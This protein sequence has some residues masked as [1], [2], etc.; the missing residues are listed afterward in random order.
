MRP[1]VLVRAGWTPKRF[2]DAAAT[3]A[4]EPAGCHAAIE[5]QVSADRLARRNDDRKHACRHYPGTRLSQKKKRVGL[6]NAPLEAER[7]TRPT[8]ERQLER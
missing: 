6:D 8:R 3:T 5:P 1:I 4:R 2:D 7:C